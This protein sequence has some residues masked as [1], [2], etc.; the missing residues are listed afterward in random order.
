RSRSRVRPARVFTR[1]QVRPD[2]AVA[3]P[4]AN[5]VP[6]LQGDRVGPCKR[7]GPD[8]RGDHGR[9][10]LSDRARQSRVPCRAATRPGDETGGLTGDETETGSARNEAPEPRNNRNG[11][12][13]GDDEHV[14]GHQRETAIGRAST[15]NP[16]IPRR[17]EAATLTASDAR[18]TYDGASPNGSNQ[19]CQGHRSAWNESGTPAD[20]HDDVLRHAVRQ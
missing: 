7:A 20:R 17:L 13:R 11:H 18:W 9:G 12:G 6:H 4:H 19:T 10:S 3:W 14:R 8:G 1:G 16:E 15:R 5:P 2:G